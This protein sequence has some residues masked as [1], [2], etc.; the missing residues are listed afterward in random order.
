[1]TPEEIKAQINWLGGIYPE[2]IISF[3][4]NGNLFVRADEEYQPYQEWCKH[5][6]SSKHETTIHSVKNKRGD[7]FAIGDYV[8]TSD[9]FP[10]RPIKYFI[11]TAWGTISACFTR[12]GWHEDIDRIIRKPQS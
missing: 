12:E 6:Y 5:M 7:T 9:F 3:K 1:M 11:I 2:G 8:S 4:S 10:G